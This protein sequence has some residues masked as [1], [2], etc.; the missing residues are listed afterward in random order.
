MHA[1]FRVDSLFL[2]AHTQTTKIMHHWS[3]GYF[4]GWAH[5]GRAGWVDRGSWVLLKYLDQSKQF[6]LSTFFLENHNMVF[7]LTLYLFYGLVT[8]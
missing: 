3:W 4:L 5:E 6:I 7:L 2:S 8:F 1:V